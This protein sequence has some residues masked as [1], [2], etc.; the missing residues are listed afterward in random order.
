MICGCFSAKRPHRKSYG[1]PKRCS[2]RL[3]AFL[4]LLCCMMLWIS[5]WHKVANYCV[6]ASIGNGDFQPVHVQSDSQLFVY[7]AFYDPRVRNVLRL[8]AVGKHKYR[9][10]EGMR[11]QSWP[12]QNLSCVFFC[13][14]SFPYLRN[15]LPSN[16]SRRFRLNSNHS[17]VSVTR[18]TSV[19]GMWWNHVESVELTCAAPSQIDN[20]DSWFVSVVSNSDSQCSRNLLPINVVR[21]AKGA[22][23]KLL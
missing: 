3:V 5:R 6:E 1:C 14:T 9:K 19:I 18:V 8:L 4:V 11:D 15:D 23:A 20:G 12:E 2:K 22:F 16:D 13:N 21:I 7:S 17:A 10:I